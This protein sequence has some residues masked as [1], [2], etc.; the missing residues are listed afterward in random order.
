MLL[1]PG[2]INTHNHLFQN[3]VKGIGDEMYLLPWVETLI[4]PTADE[5]TPEETLSRRAARLSR[6]DPQRHH[7]AD[8][9]HVR[10]PEH[11]GAP[12]G[13]RAMRDTGI[14]GFFGR[15]T[16]DLNPDSGWRD[17]WYLPLD[18]VFDQMRRSRGSS[19]AGCRCRASC[20]LPGRCA[21]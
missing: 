14:R 15:A 10:D 18:E 8:G 4:L 21:R 7:R 20:P 6:G 3:L 17:P 19:R 16:R 1:L 9:L 11:R 5:M 12:R 13:L 2:L